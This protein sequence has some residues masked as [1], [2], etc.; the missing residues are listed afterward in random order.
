MM[1]TRNQTKIKTVLILAA[2]A[3]ATLPTSANAA[4]TFDGFQSWQP[5][6]A[7]GTFDASGSDKLVVV[8]TGEH[9]FNQSA[10]GQIYD[11]TYD[12]H[13]LTKAVDVDPKKISEGGHGDTATDIWYLDNPGAV[14]TSGALAASVSGNGNN[15]VYTA[16]GL[17]G[18]AAGVGPTAAAPGA[19]SVDLTTTTAGSMVIFNIGMGGGGNT[20]S[21]LPGVTATSPVG[22]VTIDGLEAGNNWAGHAVA[23]AAISSP[24]LYTFSFDTT[25]TDVATIAAAFE[26]AYV[27]PNLPTVDAGVDMIT[28]SGMDVV[29]APTV[30]NNDTQ[31]PNRPLSH[32]WTTDAPGGYTVQWNPSNTVEAP[33]VTITPDT[34]G[35][36]QTVT[37]TLKVDLVGTSSS[38][39]DTMEI[40]VYDDACL[41]AQ[42]V[43]S[44]S[45]P[46]D[47]SDFDKNCITDLRDYAVLAAKW[48]VDYALTAPVAKP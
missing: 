47:P 33:T 18:T 4:I 44:P 5:T 31:D 13:S 20:A 27:D 45:E 10:N 35:N 40:D 48:L 43:S 22:A 1:I 37:L 17:S 12:G 29:L 8:V 11:I 32:T 34:P 7:L 15:Y 3:M 6:S 42:V 46:F 39:S 23:Y 25:K 28:L 36:P 30:V 19:A 26:D 2:V 41:A 14:H 21:P 38:A 24:G 9:N 16:I